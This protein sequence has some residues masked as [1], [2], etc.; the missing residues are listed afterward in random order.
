MLINSNIYLEVRITLKNQKK[1]Y[2][3]REKSDKRMNYHRNMK[4]HL[5][6]YRVEKERL[7][8]SITDKDVRVIVDLVLNM[9]K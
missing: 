7:I 3:I 5:H 9:K 2:L 8:P 1:K 6:K 4:T